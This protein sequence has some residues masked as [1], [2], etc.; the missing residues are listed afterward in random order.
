ME[1]AA[2]SGIYPDTAALTP[3]SKQMDMDI[4]YRGWSEAGP[5]LAHQCMAGEILR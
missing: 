4:P 2:H 1:D 3:W 5:G